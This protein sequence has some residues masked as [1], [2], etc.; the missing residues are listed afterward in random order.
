MRNDSQ[1]Q[2]FIAS[3][4]AIPDAEDARQASAQLRWRMLHKIRD[5]K[6]LA[7]KLEAYEH[8]KAYYELKPYPND[9]L[10]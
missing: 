2:G 10:E 4:R 6:T 9:E 5:A 1:L 7:E 8:Y 3:V